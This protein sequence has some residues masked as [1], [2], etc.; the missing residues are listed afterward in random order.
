VREDFVRAKNFGLIFR[1]NFPLQKSSVELYCFNYPNRVN[2]RAKDIKGV[3]MPEKRR[4]TRYTVPEIYQ[5]QITLKIKT[6]PSEFAVVA[7]LLN[8]SLSGIKIKYPF[9]LAVGSIIECSISIPEFIIQEI[10]F[11]VRVAYSIE[12]KGDGNYL[13]GGEIAQTNEELWVN[14]Y[15]KVHDFIGESLRPSDTT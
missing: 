2:E 1:N 8:I 14:A 5:E 15:F 13:I 12:D 9:P 7:E 10:T 4:Q 11:G 6:D 3:L